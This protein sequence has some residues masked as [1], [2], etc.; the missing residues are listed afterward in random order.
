MWYG[1][2]ESNI[3]IEKKMQATVEKNKSLQHQ[4]TTI[5]YDR[6]WLNVNI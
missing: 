5:R 2:G 3:Y 6:Y 4:S 1:S